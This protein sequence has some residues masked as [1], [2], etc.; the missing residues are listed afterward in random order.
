MGDPALGHPAS[1][2]RLTGPSAPAPISVTVAVDACLFAIVGLIALTGASS[3]SFVPPLI[4]GVVVL[5]IYSRRAATAL[6]IRS[7]DETP[8]GWLTV[9]AVPGGVAG[10]LA[11]NAG[12]YAGLVIM[13][14]LACVQIGE[15]IVWA[16]FRASGRATEQR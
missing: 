7:R 3:W 11:G 16:R 5:V 12:R 9:L 14:Y 6:G 10:V 4:L 2:V 15:R 13:A 1:R 8:R